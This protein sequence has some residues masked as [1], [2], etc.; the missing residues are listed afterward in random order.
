MNIEKTREKLL[1]RFYDPSYLD[2]L[3]RY[4]YILRK[5]KYLYKRGDYKNFLKIL[6]Q[7]LN[8]KIEMDFHVLIK[9]VKNVKNLK[10]D[11][12]IK[13]F[14]KNRIPVESASTVLFVLFPENFFPYTSEILRELDIDR[15]INFSEFQRIV[16]RIKK[17]CTFLDSNLDLYVLLNLDKTRSN[18]FDDLNDLISKI[19]VIDFLKITVEDVTKIRNEMSMLTKE[20]RIYLYKNLKKK[21]NPYFLKVLFE[22][23]YSEVVIDGNN[24]VHLTIHPSLKNMFHLFECLSK[25][26][27]LL[28]PFTIVF[29]K[30]IKYLLP[31]PELLIFKERFETNPNVVFHSPADELIFELHIGRKALII[32]NDRFRQYDIKSSALLKFKEGRLIT[33]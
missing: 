5:L 8:I 22:S 32:S 14:E 25:F 27:F 6:D 4:D 19:E 28:F 13:F 31:K 23:S 12:I 15:K 21:I 20:E 2:A 16:K 33:S 26:K 11:E 30:N 7:E 17:V 3:K 24:I 10:I 9:I 1:N 29:D 18:F